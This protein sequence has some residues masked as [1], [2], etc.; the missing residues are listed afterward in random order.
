M[1]DLFI[2][3]PNDVRL[4]EGTR[5]WNASG[6]SINLGGGGASLNVDSLISLLQGGISFDTV[7]SDLARSRTA[8]SSSST[9]PRP[10]PGRT[11]SRTCP[12]S[13]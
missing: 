2:D 9:P 6:F 7:G 8:T 1:I 10:S 12:A 4:T 3:A 13:G 11:S 5:F